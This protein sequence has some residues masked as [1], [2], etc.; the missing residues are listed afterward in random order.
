[1]ETCNYPCASSPRTFDITEHSAQGPVRM[2]GAG[3]LSQRIRSTPPSFNEITW[4]GENLAVEVRNLAALPTPDMQPPGP[5][6]VRL[7][8]CD[9]RNGRLGRKST[10]PVL[11]RLP[12]I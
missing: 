11:F 2:I 3:T 7:G 1:M 8:L 9:S 5:A 10:G 12:A 6:P 4:D